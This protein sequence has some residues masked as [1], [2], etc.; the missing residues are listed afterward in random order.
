MW[1]NNRLSCEAGAQLFETRPLWGGCRYETIGVRD[2]VHSG[3]CVKMFY[4]SK[5]KLKAFF[6]EKMERIEIFSE[7]HHFF[8]RN[9]KVFILSEYRFYVASVLQPFIIIATKK[10]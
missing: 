3:V 10:Q 9:P 2:Y 4:N 6:V 5:N 7:E 8:M 1:V